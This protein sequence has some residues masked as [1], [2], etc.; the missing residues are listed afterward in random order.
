LAWS[1]STD[2]K[3]ESLNKPGNGFKPKRVSQNEPFKWKSELMA[4]EQNTINYWM[5]AFGLNDF[6]NSYINV[7]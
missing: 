3:I 1:E 7:E 2:H 6:F 5:D 4:D